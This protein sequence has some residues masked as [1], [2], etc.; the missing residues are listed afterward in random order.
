MAGR[1]LSRPL[2]G[3]EREILLG[4]LEAQRV[5]YEESPELATAL[6]RVGERAPDRSLSVPELA[7]WTLTA[8]TLLNLDEALTK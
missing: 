6:V 7:A 3:P 2:A 5:R 8:S 4:A 1:V